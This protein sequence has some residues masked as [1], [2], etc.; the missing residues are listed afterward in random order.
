MD[1]AG[2]R[3]PLA[4]H[5]GAGSLLIAAQAGQESGELRQGV[6]SLPRAP[7]GRNQPVGAER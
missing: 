3:D 7:A 2:K 1:G 6:W 4:E 5:R